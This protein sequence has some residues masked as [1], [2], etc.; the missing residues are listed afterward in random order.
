MSDAESIIKELNLKPHPEGGYFAE[1]FRDEDNKV[2]LIYYL[3]KK[4]Q[5]SHWHRLTKNEILH[6]YEG[7]SLN[8]HISIDGKTSKT[9]ILGN[10][11]DCNEAV[12]LVVKAGSWFSMTSSGD[13]SLIGC[14][15]AP[16]FNYADL[17]LAPKNWEPGR[18]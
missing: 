15:V 9:K 3:L 17:E 1:S 5:R 2:S 7:H 8:V 6:F 14:T 13:Y 16:G 11:I 18:K 4:D 10:N 12:H